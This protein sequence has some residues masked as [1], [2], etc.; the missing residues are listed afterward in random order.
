MF[1]L[2]ILMSEPKTLTQK[3]RIFCESYWNA[4]TLFAVLMFLCGVV[5]GGVALRKSSVVAVGIR[6][7]DFPQHARV[8]Y[9]VNAVLWWV[10]MLGILSVHNRLGPYIMMVGKMVC[11]PLRT[12]KHTRLCRSST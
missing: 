6:L 7:A 2:Q 1:A 8:M 3:L 10:R 4:L 5:L 12:H 11:S 9:T